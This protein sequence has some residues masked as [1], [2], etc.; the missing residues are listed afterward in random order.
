MYKLKLSGMAAFYRNAFLLIKKHD[1]LIWFDM[2]TL[3]KVLKKLLITYF[4]NL[5]QKHAYIMKDT[6][7]LLL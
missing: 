5:E 4:S 3:P 1:V 6:A 7:I 2:V